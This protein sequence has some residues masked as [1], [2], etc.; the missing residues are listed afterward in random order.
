MKGWPVTTILPGTVV[1]EDG[2]LNA[3]PGF[4]QFVPRK[5]DPDVLGRPLF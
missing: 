2:T 3:E 5:L 4:G 1:V